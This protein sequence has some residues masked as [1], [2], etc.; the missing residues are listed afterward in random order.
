MA[1]LSIPPGRPTIVS[2]KVSS[3]D[4]E[5]VD[6]PALGAGPRKRMRVQVSLSAPTIKAPRSGAFIVV[7]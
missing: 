3:R 4:G 6:T 2:E 1:D 7:G 5:M